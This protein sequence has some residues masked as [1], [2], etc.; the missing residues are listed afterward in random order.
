V[1]AWAIENIIKKTSN[2]DQARSAIMPIFKTTLLSA[3]LVMR[4]T[5]RYSSEFN[6]LRKSSNEDSKLVIGEKERKKALQSIEKWFS[7]SVAE[8]LKI[9]DPYFSV[10]EL[11][12]VRQ[13]F[14]VKPECKV[15][16]LTSYK[17]Q[18]KTTKSLEDTYKD[19]WRQKCKDYR[20]ASIKI[21]IAGGEIKGDMPIHDRWLITKSSGLRLGTS[22]N[23]LGWTKTSDISLMT[24]AEAKAREIEIDSL[25]NFEVPEVG[26]EKLRYSSFKI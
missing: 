25:I 9:C 20:D 2:T 19:Y 3:E 8:Y 11:D 21:V 24:E 16:V 14:N 1:L 6:I 22:Y 7:D 15:V 26:S 23:S 10:D 17:G 5:N 4:L 13:L 18:T 12:M